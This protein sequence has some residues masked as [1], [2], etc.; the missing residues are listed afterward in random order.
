MTAP[1]WANRAMW[2]GDNLE[3]K[4]NKHAAHRPR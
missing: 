4:E 3:P 2:T 1:Y